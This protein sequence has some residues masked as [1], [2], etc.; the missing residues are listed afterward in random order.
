MGHARGYLL[1]AKVRKVCKVVKSVSRLKAKCALW[2]TEYVEVGWALELARL[3][4]TSVNSKDREHSKECC[5][6]EE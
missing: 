1:S 4:E 6:K 2:G 5:T 3:M